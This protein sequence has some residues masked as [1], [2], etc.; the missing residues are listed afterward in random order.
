M[1]QALGLKDYEES[2]GYK[3]SLAD[4]WINYVSSLGFILTKDTTHFSLK[5]YESF[6]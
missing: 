2:I 4:K 3:I 1:F 6:S 5:L